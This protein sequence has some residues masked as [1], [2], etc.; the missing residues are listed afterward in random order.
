MKKILSLITLSA[1]GAGAFAQTMV[2]TTPSNRNILLEDL[3]GIFCG[4]CPDGAMRADQLK[5]TAP[6]RVVL[7]GN[8]AGIYAAPGNVAQA[9]Y[10]LRT[11][12]GTFVDNQSDPTGYPAG[13]VNRKV[14]SNAMNPG[15]TAMSRGYWQTEAS[16]IMAEPSALN[17]AVDAYYHT[18]TQKII[19]EVEGYYTANG[20]GK[21]YLTV[22]VLQDNVDTYQSG[23][24]GYPARIQPSGL[25]RQM[26][27]L[28]AYLT[29]SLTGE[30]IATTTSTTFFSRHYEYDVIKV[31]PDINPVMEDMKIAVWVGEDMTFSEIITAVVTDAAER[32][33]GINEATSLEGLQIYPNPFAGQATLEFNLG[34]A[35]TIEINLYDVTGKMIQNTPS[36]IYNA[37][38]HRIAIEGQGLENGLY[39]VN[40]LAED[41]IVTRRIVLNR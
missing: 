12:E 8:H 37:G 33:V 21:D 20:N 17:L 27:V 11:S 7:I 40:I 32:P 4:Y 5:A 9:Q 15:K 35:Q 23:A 38:N 2:S 19:V 28:R 30:E 36:K 31:G 10:D 22:A 41:G 25:Y 34:E 18:G 3:T 16:I 26:D 24:S 13:N 39:Y 6:S 14:T 1:V 29:T